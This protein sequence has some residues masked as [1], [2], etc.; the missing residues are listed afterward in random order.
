MISLI[1]LTVCTFS[2]MTP[3]APVRDPNNAPWAPRKA[4]P[5]PQP[6]I[7]DLQQDLANAQADVVEKIADIRRSEEREQ[8]ERALVRDLVQNRLRRGGPALEEPLIDNFDWANLRQRQYL[9]LARS[10]TELDRL[11]RELDFLRGPNL[12]PRRLLF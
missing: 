12:I 8:A 3:P 11:Q 6:T 4:T 5:P 2:A 1:F 7:A 9:D 10:F